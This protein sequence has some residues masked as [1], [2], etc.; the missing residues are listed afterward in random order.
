MTR[1]IILSLAVLLM[2]PWAEPAAC[3]EAGHIW[4]VQFE[5]DFFGGGTDRHF[6]HGTRLSHLTKPI[7]WMTEAADR[8]PWFNAEEAHED[9]AGQLKA[10][11]TISFG[12]SIYTPEDIAVREMIEEDR[13]YAG[14]LYAGFGLVINRDDKRYDQVEL[15][16]GVVG[17]S[18]FAEE[19]QREWHGIFGLQRPNGWDHQLKDELGVALFY[20]Q[21][22]RFQTSDSVWGL[23]FDVVPHVGGVVGNVFTYAAT[24]FTVRLGL[25]LENDFGSP[26]IRPSL[27]GAGYYERRKF[28]FYLFAGGEGRAVLQNIFLDGNT[29]TASHSVDKKPLVGDVQ[30]GIAVQLSRFRITYTQI[31]RTKEYDGQDTADQFGALSLSCEF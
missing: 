21:A 19:V 16:I 25:N 24:G 10:R 29:F 2:N 7:P 26:R 27:P 9:S 11:A 3:N 12:Q 4:G 22:R 30:A 8:L 5:N 15:D 14:W 18:S 31:Y 20:E 17:P 1:T 28:N 13:P 6:T 23:Q